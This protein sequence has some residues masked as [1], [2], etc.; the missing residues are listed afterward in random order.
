MSVVATI[1]PIK[2]R[3]LRRAELERAIGYGRSTINAWIAEGMPTVGKDRS[4]RNLFDLAAVEAWL[5]GRMPAV[6]ATPLR[7]AS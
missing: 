2:R 5:E 6:T 3:P 4:G 1:T 7:E